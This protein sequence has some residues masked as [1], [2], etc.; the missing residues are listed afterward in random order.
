MVFISGGDV[1]EGMQVL[2]KRGMDLLLEDLY[3]AGKPFF[4]ISAGSIMLTKSWVRWRDPHD[5]ASAELFSC[6]GLASVYCDTHGESDGWAELKALLRL[7]PEG[8]AGFGIVSGSALAVSV[9]G[10]VSSWG[11]EVHVFRKRKNDVLQ[12][13]SLKNKM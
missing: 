1:E 11:G 4:G 5:E 8:T 2:Q 12:E 3:I 9:D 6:L 10:T 7:C 13:K